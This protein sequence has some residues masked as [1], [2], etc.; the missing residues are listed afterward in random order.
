MIKSVVLF[1]G[2]RDEANDRVLSG[3]EYI[4]QMTLDCWSFKEKINAEP[5]LQRHL[6]VLK[7]AKR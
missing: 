6:V 5:R 2:H 4:W 7:K 1:K 3:L